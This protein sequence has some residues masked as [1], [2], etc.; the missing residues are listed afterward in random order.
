MICN[1]CGER[2]RLHEDL[3]DHLDRHGRCPQRE[4]DAKAQAAAQIRRTISVNDRME[5]DRFEKWCKEVQRRMVS[6]GEDRVTAMNKAYE[7]EYGV[8]LKDELEKK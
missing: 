7:E 1:Y 4:V 6:Y 3:R 8:V 5:L 2:F